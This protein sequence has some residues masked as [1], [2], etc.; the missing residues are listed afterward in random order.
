MDLLTAPPLE[1]GN[2]AEIKKRFDA[3]SNNRDVRGLTA[4]ASEA[5]PDS[6]IGRAALS[7]IGTIQSNAA[8][9]K[10][11]VDPIDK[12][13][14]TTT[15]EGR[16]QIART[17]V[18]TADHPMYG[19]AL[20][21]YVMGQKEDAYKLFTGGTPKTSI[22]YAKDNGNIIQITTNGL[23]Q[24]LSYY[25]TQEGRQISMEEYSRRGGSV[26][27]LDNTIAG[28]N[29][30][31]NRKVYNA[32]FQQEQQSLN[33]W[34]QVY[35]DLSPKIDYINDWTG[36][37]KTD[38]PPDQWSELLRTVSSSIGQASN[39]SKSRTAFDQLQKN[40]STAD[41]IKVDDKIAAQTGAAVGQVLK[42]SG[43]KLVST[44]GKFSESL[45]KLKQ[46]TSTDSQSAENS[47]NASQTFDSIVKSD[48]FQNALKGK[49]EKEKQLYVQQLEQ[50][51][52][53]SNEVGS[54]LAKTVDKYGKPSF[55][56]L[57]TS[58]SFTD[59]QALVMTQ[60]AQHK[61]N[62]EQLNSYSKYFNKNA[63][64]YAKTN[65][66]PV[67]GAIAN[68]YLN[69]P[70][71]VENQETWSKQ[72][73]NILNNEYQARNQAKTAPATATSP[74]FGTATS[75]GMVPPPV[76]AAPV[77]AAPVTAAPVTANMAPAA[78]ADRVTPAASAPPPAPKAAK[79]PK[80]IPAGSVATGK[81]STDGKKVYK[82]PNGSL[83]VED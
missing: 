20:V 17:F 49:T 34:N 73:D 43:D 15:P 62:S 7:Q 14:G 40:A 57:P 11:K 28:L 79:L 69:S 27:S 70:R 56:S 4:L 6:L 78:A 55:I 61:Y 29:M 80:G 71:F 81:F 58:A 47:K 5:G 63:E 32:A 54:E 51:L 82:A 35:R 31:E 45:D 8:E 18:S 1:A 60:M 72:I 64:M 21:A 2:D 33:N 12:A 68:A 46:R 37:F 83:H 3:A 76:T 44:D 23:G 22:E 16:Q 38:L 52:R 66:L 24:P 65:T 26:S 30:L 50:V 25:D 10:S 41:G 59:P 77:V 48:K 53:F 42:V 67:P 19:Q 75:E 13:G 9:F 36:K 74:S 39:T